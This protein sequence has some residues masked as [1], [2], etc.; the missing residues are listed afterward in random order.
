MLLLGGMQLQGKSLVLQS[1]EAYSQLLFHLQSSCSQGLLPHMNFVV[2]QIYH[3]II[4][5]FR[6]NVDSVLISYIGR[7]RKLT[8]S[9][10]HFQKSS[11]SLGLLPPMNFF[12][13]Q[14]YL[15][16]N[17]V[18]DCITSSIIAPTLCQTALCSFISNDVC[19]VRG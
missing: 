3:I 8:L 18:V 9:S 16:G 4:L 7:V 15:E 5:L 13:T 11:Y 1:G 19:S 6:W 12:V 14:I 17:C 2:T 10:F